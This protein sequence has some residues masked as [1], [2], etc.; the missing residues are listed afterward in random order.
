MQSSSWHPGI[1]WRL[2]GD[3]QT[4][5][6]YESQ[7]AHWPV[8]QY[9]KLRIASIGHITQHHSMSM[10]ITHAR[11]MLPKQID[12]HLREEP[13]PRY[14]PQIGHKNC[15]YSGAIDYADSSRPIRHSGH[16]QKQQKCIKW[17]CS[18]SDTF[19]SISWNFRQGSHFPPRHFMILSTAVR[20]W[21]C[22][23]VSTRDLYLPAA[24]LNSPTLAD[25][26]LPI[27]ASRKKCYWGTNWQDLL[28]PLSHTDKLP[29]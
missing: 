12:W 10:A 26:V 11:A 9:V 20:V 2:F 14:L 4:S 19:P 25:H 8:N 23:W 7:V 1:V 15:W 16:N 28:I 13:K 17:P 27:T 24:V 22:S 6:S 29:H 3:K 18:A 5:K 21:L